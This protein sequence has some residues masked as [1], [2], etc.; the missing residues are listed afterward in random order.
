[1]NIT[2]PYPS[3][4]EDSPRTTT[5]GMAFVTEISF[6]VSDLGHLPRR[7]EPVAMKSEMFQVL[8]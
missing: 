6:T 8:P 7:P 3:L 5:I 4:H 2:Y 1:M